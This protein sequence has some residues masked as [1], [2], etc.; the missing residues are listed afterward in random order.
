ME[1]LNATKYIDSLKQ[2]L[3]QNM[4]ILKSA[5]YTCQEC[6]LLI[7]LGF[8]FQSVCYLIKICNGD[9]NVLCLESKCY[10]KRNEYDPYKVKTRDFFSILILTGPMTFEKVI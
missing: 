1:K 9:H 2:T 7:F 6:G 3:C 4:S 10:V 8:R 5:L